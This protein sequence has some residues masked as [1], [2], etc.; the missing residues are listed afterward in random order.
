MK[1]VGSGE[2]V[3]RCPTCEDNE[4]DPNIEYRSDNKHDVKRESRDHREL[5]P[6]HRPIARGPNGERVYA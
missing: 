2:Y 4:E 1:V 3:S 5:H 6:D